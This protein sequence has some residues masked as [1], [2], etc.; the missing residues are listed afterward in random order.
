MADKNELKD[1]QD[2]IKEVAECGGHTIYTSRISKGTVR[3]LRELG[4]KLY[5]FGGMYR[6][7][8]RTNKC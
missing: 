5:G 7:R 3:R 1:I 6:I 2:Y 4:Y 8:W